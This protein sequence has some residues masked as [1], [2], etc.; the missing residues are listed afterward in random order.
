MSR[1]V[2][3]GLA[4]T[5]V[6][7]A[8]TY[9]LAT[10]FSAGT[11]Y[12]LTVDELLDRGAELENKPIRVSGTVLGDGIDWNPQALHLRF[13]VAEE[14]QPLQVI[15]RGVR[16]DNFAE[17]AQVILEGK[18]T[19]DGVFEAKTLLMTCP[20]RYEAAPSSDS[21]APMHEPGVN[22]RLPASHEI[23]PAPGVR[24]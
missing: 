17:G 22:G 11:L 13:A 14:G 23:G 5:V 21:A 15:Y 10:A 9:L 2:R 19:R 8:L 4:L 3:F 12:Y 6:A 1:K 7:V 16:P 24:L 18:L 20:S